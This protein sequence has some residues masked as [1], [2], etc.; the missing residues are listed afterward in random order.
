MKKGIYTSLL[1]ATLSFG[2][3]TVISNHT[4]PAPVEAKSVLKKTFKVGK[5]ATY[6]GVS[7]KVNSFQYVEP[8]EYDSVDEGKH[9]IVANVTIKNKSRKSYDYNPYDFKLNVKPLDSKVFPLQK[10]KNSYFIHTSAR[11]TA[12]KNN[13]LPDIQ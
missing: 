2:G 13:P 10:S 11:K 4:Q 6:K 9:F 8:G 5:T 3:A 12:T 7:L 1:L